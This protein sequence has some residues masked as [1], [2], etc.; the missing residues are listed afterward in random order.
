MNLFLSWSGRVS[1]DVAMALQ[2]W[3]PYML[4][5]VRP[6]ISNDIRTG[7]DWRE[8]LVRQL[9]GAEYGIVCV[10]PF[11]IHKPWMNFESGALAGHLKALT[12]F[13]FRVD[14]AS[15]GNGPLATVELVEFGRNDQRNKTEFY[16]LLGSINHRLPEQD[17]VP[18]DILSHNFDH[19]WPQLE[20][21]LLNISETSSDETRTAYPWLR[22]FEDIEVHDLHEGDVIWFVTSDVVTYALR[23]KVRERIERNLQRVC[24]RYLIPEPRGSD[25]LSSITQFRDFASSHPGRLE[26][27]IFERSVFEKQAPSHYILIVSPSTSGN[28]VSRVFVHIPSA[29]A[30][31]DYW[32]DADE[33]AAINFFGRFL[34]LWNCPTDRVSEEV[35]W[36]NAPASDELHQQ[37]GLDR[38]ELTP[39]DPS[40]DGHQ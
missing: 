39:R 26:Y 38:P 7:A 18:A 28:S 20:H 2:K 15:L 3:L 34:Q 37:K 24:Y 5:S 1:Q 22:T 4:H 13:L 25:E 27:A 35:V 9:R 36:A 16:K 21:D 33:R 31:T 6:F 17:R 12:P 8:E 30:G 29:E 32:F 14:R 10:T 40:I 19:W 23:T 11:N